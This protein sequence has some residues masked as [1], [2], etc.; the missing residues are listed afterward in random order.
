ML[1]FMSCLFLQLLHS[2]VESV[3]KRIVSGQI[4]V[5]VLCC[6]NFDLIKMKFSNTEEMFNAAASIEALSVIG[7]YGWL[8]EE[9]SE[10]VYS[11]CECYE[12]H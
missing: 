11:L 6:K 12:N 7:E 4:G 10:V 2:A 9:G 1:L 8:L 5:I 3:D